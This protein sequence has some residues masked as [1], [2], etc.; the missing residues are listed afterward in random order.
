MKLSTISRLTGAMRASREPT[1]MAATPYSWESPLPP[2]DCTAWST[3]RVE[4]SA[5][6]RPSL[7][8]ECVILGLEPQAQLEERAA[9]RL[10]LVRVGAALGRLRQRSRERLE[11][12]GDAQREQRGEQQEHGKSGETG[13]GP[14]EEIHD[15][16]VSRVLRVLMRRRQVRGP[17]REGTM[18]AGR[19]SRQLHDVTPATM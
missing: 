15:L 3:A 10:I 1:S 9:Q 4:A 14:P 5:R 8:A 18:P 12:R 19:G 11:P 17:S 13:S 16:D 6:E 2:M 7:H